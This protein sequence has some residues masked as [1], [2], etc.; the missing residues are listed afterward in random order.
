[1]AKPTNTDVNFQNNKKHPIVY[2]FIDSQNLNLGTSKDLYNNNK[3]K[4][5]T[6]WKLDFEKFRI[7]LADKFRISKAFLFIGYITENRKMYEQLKSFGYELVFKPTTKDG[8]G[9]PKGN[10]DAELVLH[11]AALE[12]ENYDRAIIVSGD[13]DFYCLHEYL[14]GKKKLFKIIIPNKKSMSN[15][16]RKFDQYKKFLVDDKDI[17]EH[18]KMGGVHSSNT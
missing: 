5:Y 14:D 8:F 4:I 17:L 12:Y 15:L 6:G 10:I 2:A 16:L 18:K 13:G 3:K 1:M 11:S 7:Y 9:K